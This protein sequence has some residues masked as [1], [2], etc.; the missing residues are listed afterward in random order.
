[1]NDMAR[2]VAALGAVL[3]VVAM[4]I[5][6][7]P[8]HVQVANHRHGCTIAMFAGLPSEPPTP[9][10]SEASR[11]YFACKNHT[12]MPFVLTLAIGTIGLSLLMGVLVLRAG[13]AS[14]RSSLP[15]PPNPGH[16]LT[17][18]LWLSRVS[19]IVFGRVDVIGR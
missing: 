19:S 3:M 5:G 10:G 14:S 17:K 13:A 2:L 11:A 8:Q 6:V 7:W 9:Y 1:M 16:D 15:P 18:P 12:Q 4:V